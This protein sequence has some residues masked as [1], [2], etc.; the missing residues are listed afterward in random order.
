MDSAMIHD[1]DF[2]DSALEGLQAEPKWLDSK[3]L[4][5]AEGSAIFEQITQLP[6]YYPTRTETRILKDEIGAL[7]RVLDPGTVLVELGS[8]ASVKTRILLDAASE[9]GA[10]VPVDISAE[11]LEET[12]E[13]LRE[14]YPGTPIR[15]VVGDFTQDIRLPAALD[16]EP[17]TAFFPG[18]TIGNLP[19][20]TAA[21]MLDRLRH[22]PGIKALI[23]GLDLVKDTTT[24]VEAYDDAAGVTADFNL[25]LLRRMNREIG[26]DFDLSAFHHE[27]RWNAELSRIEMHLVS[28]RAQTVTV[29]GTPITFAEGESIHTENSRKYTR[30]AF[31]AIADRG[32]WEIADFL[33]DGDQLFAV[34]VLKPKQD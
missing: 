16:A 7:S 3:W 1:R 6:E 19:H 34:A 24:L 26:A 11:F 32:G 31:A 14:A 18:S 29:A 27:A 13:G 21:A 28:D 5:D 4:Y 12:A 30:E 20:D 22:W 33:T 25:N 15:P 23:L 10:Y 17:K 8:G 9:L 2:A